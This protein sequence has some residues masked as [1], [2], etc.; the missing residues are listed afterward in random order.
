M[1]FVELSFRW[2]RFIAEKQG[3]V[4][5]KRA[6]K[7][8]AGRGWNLSL[9]LS[10]AW[11]NINISSFHFFGASPISRVF[12]SILALV[13][14]WE[15]LL[16][17]GKTNVQHAVK[18][19]PWISDYSLQWEKTK[20]KTWIILSTLRMKMKRKK[21]KVPFFL[22]LDCDSWTCIIRIASRFILVC[23]TFEVRYILLRGSHTV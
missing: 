22:L 17:I 1:S 19:K 23:W 15:K 14:S 13:S 20:T 9:S 5:G 12:Y 16:F 18:L 10:F 11:K 2:I 6:L 21:K 7:L 4:G 8:A 3:S